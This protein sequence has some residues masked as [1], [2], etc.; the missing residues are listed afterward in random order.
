MTS[1]LQWIIAYFYFYLFHE[2]QRVSKWF[3]DQ[4]GNLCMFNWLFYDSFFSEWAT[5]LSEYAS[6][7]L[8][9]IW[10]IKLIFAHY[11]STLVQS[12]CVMCEKN[13]LVEINAEPSCACVVLRTSNHQR[14][15]H[16]SE[17]YKQ[18]TLAWLWPQTTAVV[19]CKEQYIECKFALLQIVK[20]NYHCLD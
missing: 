11:V 16:F 15:Q 4:H 5:T 17:F 10:D 12:V 14:D 13:S 3:D 8:P 2:I 20:L 18:E 19:N 1:T 9:F 7:V 6:G